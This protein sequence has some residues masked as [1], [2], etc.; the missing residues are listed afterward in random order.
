MTGGGPALAT[1]ALI[2]LLYRLGFVHFEIGLASAL[3]MVLFLALILLTILQFR[4]IG[5]RVHYAYE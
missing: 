5:R 3:A 4:M 2:V 1:E